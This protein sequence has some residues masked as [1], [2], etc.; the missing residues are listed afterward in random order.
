[1]QQILVWCGLMEWLWYTIDFARVR[2]SSS[3]VLQWVC[4]SSHNREPVLRLSVFALL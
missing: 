3:T 1:M 4:G 2:L